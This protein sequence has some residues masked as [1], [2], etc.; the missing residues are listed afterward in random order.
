MPADDESRLD[1]LRREIDRVS[2]EIVERLNER[3]RYAL[4][5]A[6]E[7]RR[8]NLP[9]HDPCR[10]A[11]ILEMLG[12]RSEGPLDPA[13]VSAIFRRVLDASVALMEQHVETER[14]DTRPL[15]R[16]RNGRKFT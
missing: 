7:K 5:V 9:M 4:E 15:R 16:S 12:S 2:L 13:A 6:E 8:R 11:E 10:E 14:H 1:E 3:M